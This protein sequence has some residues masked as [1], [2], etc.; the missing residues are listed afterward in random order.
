MIYRRARGVE[1]TKKRQPEARA[2]QR[3]LRLLR[4]WRREDERFCA[5]RGLDIDLIPVVHFYGRPIDK[6]RSSW[7]SVSTAAGLG[8]DAV[9]HSLRHTAI[10]WAAQHG[11]DPWQMCGYFGI[12]MDEMQSTYLHHHP[13][14][15][16]SV[17]AA[18][19]GR[20]A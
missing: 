13:D 3:L 20:R 11:A 17:T 2:P 15:Q 4:I 5:A 12:T 16:S 14:Y 6:L 1:E 19:D 8:P 7:R 18:F 9:A 10:T